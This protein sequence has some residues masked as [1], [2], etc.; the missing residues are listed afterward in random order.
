MKIA[1]SLG[2]RL[3][4]P[5]AIV[6]CVSAGIFATGTIPAEAATVTHTLPVSCNSK[7]VT[8]GVTVTQG[9]LGTFKVK[10]NSS[11]PNEVTSVWAR[12]QKGHTLSHKIVRNGGTVTWT[13][14]K[15][16]KYTIRATTAV[17]QNYKGPD[18]FGDGNYTWKYNVN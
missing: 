16:G 10:Q 18:P 3:G 11:K 8:S 15:P 6:A 7:I 1:R 14:V 5:A 13:S 2:R 17:T 9:K 12:D 4:I